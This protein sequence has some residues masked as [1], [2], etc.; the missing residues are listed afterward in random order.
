MPTAPPVPGAPAPPGLPEPT[1]EVTLDASNDTDN[2]PLDAVTAPSLANVLLD[3]VVYLVKEEMVVPGIEIASVLAEPVLTTLTT[4]DVSLL[5]A[6]RDSP[7]PGLAV[8]STLY[9][10]GRTN[11]DQCPMHPPRLV[12]APPLMKL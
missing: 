2:E 9:D 3:D 12:T 4:T 5:Y 11:L 10:P 6:E 8:A 1:N 7:D